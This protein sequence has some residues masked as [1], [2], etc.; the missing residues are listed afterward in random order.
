[1][2]ISGVV[3]F[4]TFLCK[5]VC[6]KGVPICVCICAM[7]VFIVAGVA[8]SGAVSLFVVKLLLWEIVCFFVCLGVLVW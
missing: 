2:L 3:L 7:L 1:M 5:V 4:N 8:F 6:V